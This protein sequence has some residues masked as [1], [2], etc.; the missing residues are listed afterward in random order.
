MEKVLFRNIK[1]NIIDNLNKANKCIYIA[2]A[3]FTNDELFKIILNALDKN[4]HVELILID[5]CINRNEFGL[6][7]KLFINKGGH[8]FFSTNVK[9]MHNKFCIID[10]ALI[11]TG[12]YNWTYYAENRNWE[13]ILI[14]NDGNV[15]DEYIKEFEYIKTQ[16]IETKEYY[17]YKLN[18]VAPFVLLNNYDYLY[19][20]IQYKSR[21]IGKEYSTY[22]S[23]LK[24]NIIVERKNS[25]ESPCDVSPDVYKTYI[26]H[27]LG[28]RTT[29]GKKDL[30]S[31]LILKGTEIPYE[32]KEIYFTPRDNQKE[33]HCETFL[34]ESID[35]KQ[36]RRIGKIVLNDIPPLPKGQGKMEVTFKIS[37]DK[38]LHVIATNMHTRTFVEAYYY[39]KDVL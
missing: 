31:F 5:D 27:S 21:T 32:K 12:S 30:T 2:V 38:T 33:L 4:I 23:V 24:E 11:I 15:V 8:L 29:D 18:E 7:F 9:N 25:I 17:H 10:N 35:P 20:E 34:G 39:L 14:S 1:N 36:N 37:S 3:W 26:K 16:I 22:L 6:D 19:E 28:I 13:N